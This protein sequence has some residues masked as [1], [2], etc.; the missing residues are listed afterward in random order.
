[1]A[2]SEKL[3][4]F[5]IRVFE[6][7]PARFLM[8]LFEWISVIYCLIDRKHRKIAGINIDIAFP[9]MEEKR[10]QKLVKESYQNLGRTIAEIIKIGKY[11]ENY[12]RGKIKFEGLDNLILPYEKGRGVFAVTGHFG[13]WELMAYAF[14]KKVTGI[15]VV[16]RPQGI[17]FI[18]G[19][20]DEK[21]ALGGNSVIRKFDSAREI[22]R[23]IRDGRIVGVLMDQDTN[24]RMGTFVDF[25][26]I[27]ACTLD[28]VPRIAFLTGASIV[29]VFVFRDRADK[30]SHTVRIY[31]PVN[32]DTE[33]KEEFIRLSLERINASL[34]KVITEQPEQWLW[35]HRRWRT[36]P[37]EGKAIYDI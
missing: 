27:P 8:W 23:R 6:M 29:P 11:D 4:K 9:G 1:M 21:R 10:K 36:R 34:E 31:E 33:E 37:P 24:V 35:F 12:L 25:F 20:I 14:G 13:N 19:Y 17:E 28:A 18:D 32:P 30:L 7:M 26:G 5:I 16:V 2:L 3:F 15:D 22:I